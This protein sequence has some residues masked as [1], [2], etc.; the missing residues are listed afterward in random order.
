MSEEVPDFRGGA[1]FPALHER[2]EMIAEDVP[3][4]VRGF[5]AVGG[6]LARNAFAPARHAVYICF[7]QDDAADLRALHAGFEWSKQLHRD[8]SQCNFSNAHD[9]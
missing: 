6:S 9:S 4:R 3:R 8:F 1:E 7:N 2:P 5:R